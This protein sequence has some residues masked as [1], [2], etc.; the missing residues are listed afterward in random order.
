MHDLRHHIREPK[1]TVFR[2]CPRP[3]RVIHRICG[4]LIGSAVA[5]LATAPCARSQPASARTTSAPTKT[6]SASKSTAPPVPTAAPTPVPETKSKAQR[7][8]ARQLYKRGRRAFNL[9]RF[10]E[11]L[12]LF[13]RAYDRLPLSGFLYNIAQCHRFMGNCKKAVFFYRG[14][15]RDNPGSPDKALVENLIARCEKSLAKQEARRKT[16]ATFFERGRRAYRLGQ[17]EEALSL[18]QSAYKHAALPGYLYQIGQCHRQLGHYRKAIHAYKGYLRENPGTP[19]TASV[20]KRIAACQKKLAAQK[21]KLEAKTNRTLRAGSAGR[22][23]GDGKHAQA[24]GPFYTRWWFWTAVAGGVAATALAVGLGVGLTQR[25][26]DG[27]NL[28]S[29]TLG[30]I[31]WR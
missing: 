30:T 24:R 5:L 12:E 13:T 1:A 2:H 7:R 23:G 3:R 20:Q 11:A 25:D 8:K 19:K 6:S 28:P 17:F 18:F 10:D 31:D 4:V 22:R 26:E 15:L 29:T 14:Y 9:G 27:M 21:K 16:A